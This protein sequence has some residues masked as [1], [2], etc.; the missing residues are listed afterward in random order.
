MSRTTKSGETEIE[1]F[2]EVIANTLFF[3][4]LKTSNCNRKLRGHGDLF[5]FTVDEE[6]SY[7]NYYYDFGPLNI[8]CLYK[9]CTKLNK[10]LQY[11]KGVK[12]IVHYTCNHPDKKANATFL[13]GAYCVIYLNMQP[14]NIM[15]MLQNVGPF[16]PFLDASQYPCQFT[17]K[18]LDCLQ[19]ISKAI[20]FNFF[21]FEDFN[22]SEYD[23]YNK[24]EFGD[25]NWLVPRK[26]L[27]FI[28][29]TDNRTSHPPEFYIKYF[30]KN[31]VK[32]VIR[33]NNV[34]YDSYAFMQVGIQHYN[35]IFPDGSTPPKDIL[36]KFLYIS[37]TAPAAIAVHCKAGL[38]RTGSLIGAYLIKH[39]HMSAREAIAWLRICRPGS[40]IGQQQIWLE[41]IQSWLWRIG[42]QY[43][44]EHFGEGD[45]IP[46]HK[47]GIYSKIWPTEREKMIKES[48]RT[49]RTC[50][51]T[52]PENLLQ[53][54]KKSKAL[55]VD[56]LH[57]D[58][59]ILPSGDSFKNISKLLSSVHTFKKFRNVHDGGSDVKVKKYSKSDKCINCT[60][61]DISP[62]KAVKKKNS[63]KEHKM[64]N[65]H[66]QTK[67][68][69][70]VQTSQ[71]DK[72]N[73]IKVQRS[74]KC[75]L[76]NV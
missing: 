3:A 29:P 36:L 37:E 60:S 34:L 14:K 48:R 21:N 42:S 44:I 1:S 25:I 38:G 58:S 71:G 22:S 73:D 10:Y 47:Y 28:G 52:E 61:T 41:K 33:L 45:K 65:S 53:M 56:K 64:Q 12:G 11:A 32:T 69:K 16:R 30:I 5:Y 43:R 70:P 49:F 62:K 72:L 35:L 59:K 13:I 24:L 18:L 15:K 50:S 46:R 4:V 27:A 8:S 23:L 63:D 26:F 74:R 2:V 17:L 51:R 6:L 40:V 57:T 19:A 76:H 31:D 55:S 75:K 68:L 20:A 39:Y 67:Q 9:Y 66:A 54:Q 7:Q